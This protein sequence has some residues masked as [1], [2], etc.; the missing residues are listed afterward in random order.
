MKAL[1]LVLAVFVSAILLFGCSDTRQDIISANNTDKMPVP[2]KGDW[3]GLTYMTS[4]T[5]RLVKC[6]GNCTHLG[7][8]EADV[9]YSVTYNAPPPNTTGGGLENGSA[10]M[11][12]ANGDKVYLG[13]LTGTW[14]FANYPPTLVGFTCSGNIVGGTG[15]FTGATGNFQGTGT[16]NFYMTEPTRPQEVWY[17]WTGSISY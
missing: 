11:V 1:S 10:T 5:G 2:F 7:L 15:R 12:A 3:E 8:Y 4:E 13:N 6:T 17:N 9:T 14:W 16:Q